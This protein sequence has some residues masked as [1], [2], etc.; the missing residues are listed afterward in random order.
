[1]SPLRL[2]NEGE[3][4]LVVAYSRECDEE[5]IEAVVNAFHTA[6]VDVFDEPT[7]LA[8]WVDPAVFED[9]CWSSDRLLYFC[10]RIWSHQVVLTPEE[11]RIY[12]QQ[13]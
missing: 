1:M 13:S 7:T 4:D 9:L 10:V 2:L 6:D 3:L 5:M 12:R 8:D 11:V